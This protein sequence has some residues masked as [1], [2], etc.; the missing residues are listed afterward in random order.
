M[1]NSQTVARFIYFTYSLRMWFFPHFFLSLCLSLSRLSLIFGILLDSVIIII[2]Y[3]ITIL[4]DIYEP[5]E[6]SVYYTY[7]YRIVSTSRSAPDLYSPF[8]PSPSLPPLVS[9]SIL[10]LFL[11]FLQSTGHFVRLLAVF[12]DSLERLYA[13]SVA[14][15]TNSLCFETHELFRD[16]HSN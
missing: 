8:T 4:K 14:L 15:E 12:G 6:I 3:N 11:L 2:N 16:A 13:T 1:A 9:V 5:R 10:F 7:I